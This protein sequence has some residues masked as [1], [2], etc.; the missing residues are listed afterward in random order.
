MTETTNVAERPSN[1]TFASLALMPHAK[2]SA[3]PMEARFVGPEE[4]SMETFF[5][6]YAEKLAIFTPSTLDG[7]IIQDR[8]I[9]DSL[10]P[11]FNFVWER[12]GEGVSNQ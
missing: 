6:I 9:A 1:V 7:V 10:R 12:A 2:Q 11:F 5:V 4:F 8:A 3:A